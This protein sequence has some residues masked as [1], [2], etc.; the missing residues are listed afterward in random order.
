MHHLFYLNGLFYCSQAVPKIMIQKKSGRI[1]N[2]GSVLGG[3]PAR[4]Q[5]AFVA[6][7]AGNYN[8]TKALAKRLLSHIPLR[9]PGKVD[10]VANAVLFLSGKESS[11]ITGHVLT[12]DGGWTYGCFRDFQAKWKNPKLK[13]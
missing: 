13:R 12:V 9:R 7:K 11:Y 2:I 5:I 6:V 1:L 3:I 4:K 8:M 10:D